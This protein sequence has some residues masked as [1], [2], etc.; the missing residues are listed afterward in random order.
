MGGRREL[1]GLRKD[2]TEVPVEIG[3]SSFESNGAQQVVAT[4]V[5]IS[6]RKQAEKR[7]AKQTLELSRSN[8]ELEQFA[9]AALHDFQEP[10]RMVSSYCGL[11][12]RR[13][14]DK[15]D[16]DTNEFIGFAID[17]ATRMKH[18]I[19]ALLVYSRVGRSQR[20]FSL[21]NATDCLHA[22][23]KNLGKAIEETQAQVTSDP[24]PVVF[25]EV[26]QLMQVFQNLIG[27]AIKF[28]GD[29]RPII[30]V[31]A[32]Q[33]SEDEKGVQWEFSV[34]DNGIGIEPEHRDRAFVIFQR[35]HTREEYPGH[36]MGLAITKKIIE[37]HGGRIRVESVTGGGTTF[38]F[39]LRGEVAAVE[40]PPSVRDAAA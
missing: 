11:L 18:L 23:I 19:D 9:Y 36:G 15:L 33:A 20:L 16:Q 24:L 32:R 14:K 10:L 37:Y 35:L 31:S 6:G 29:R 38:R 40:G 27:N 21:F 26:P 39:T 34:T 17:G 2:G 22:A 13:Y 1:F 28:R 8:N 30:H 7:L 12:A 25:G 4:V 3:L 5:D